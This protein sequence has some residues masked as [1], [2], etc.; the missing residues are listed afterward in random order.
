MQDADNNPQAAFDRIKSA[1]MR[2]SLPVPRNPWE[3]SNTNPA[4]V[5][6][7]LPDETSRGELETFIWRGLQEHRVVPCVEAYLECLRANDAMPEKIDKARVYAFLASLERPDIR[8]AHAGLAHQ[9]TGPA[10]RRLLDLIPSPADVQ[11]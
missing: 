4:V 7:V 1:L 3:V 11:L 2:S 5:G 10:M 9:M 8:L 6:L